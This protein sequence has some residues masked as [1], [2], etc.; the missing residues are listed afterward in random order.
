VC[1]PGARGFKAPE[2]L[3]GYHD[4]SIDWWNLGVFMYQVSF[5]SLPHLALSALLKRAF[6]GSG[7][8]RD[9]TASDRYPVFSMSWQS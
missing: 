4:Y 2:M 3:K 7:T 9:N 6:I 5:S 8:E 1:V